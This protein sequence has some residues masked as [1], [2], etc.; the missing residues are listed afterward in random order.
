MNQDMNLEW[1]VIYF[2]A[3]PNRKY[4]KLAVKRCV[5][6]FYIKLFV[7]E[8]LQFA[9]SLNIDA[10]LCWPQHMPLVLSRSLASVFLPLFSFLFF[11]FTFLFTVYHQFKF[12]ACLVHSASNKKNCKSGITYPNWRSS[13]FCWGKENYHTR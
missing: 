11:H 10:L 5:Q 13:G 9:A 4:S 12:L 8:A 6:N 2:V 7:F 1:C 3:R